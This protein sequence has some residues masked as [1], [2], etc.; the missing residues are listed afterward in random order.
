[1]KKISFNIR[2]DGRTLELSTG[3]GKAKENSRYLTISQDFD[4]MLITAIDRLLKANRIDRLSL[5]G[6][7]MPGKM[8]PEA[9]SMMILK[10]VDSGLGV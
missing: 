4:N 5:K 3:E 9:V 8:R 6:L 10:A 2:I 7:K 1:M